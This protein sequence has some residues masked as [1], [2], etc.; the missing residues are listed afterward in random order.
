MLFDSV[1]RGIGADERQAVETMDT[2]LCI[3][4]GEN[5]P[6]IRLD[7]MQS[8]KYRALWRDRIFVIAGAGHAPHWQCPKSFNEILLEF[9]SLR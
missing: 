7:Y 9:L 1:F 3:V 2:P 8:L 6:F 5:D 4:H